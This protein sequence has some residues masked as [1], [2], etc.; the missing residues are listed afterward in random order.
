[1]PGAGFIG[2]GVFALAGE[3]TSPLLGV[4][5]IGIG[6]LLVFFGGVI[7]LIEYSDRRHALALAKKSKKSE[8]K[9]VLILCLCNRTIYI[10]DGKNTHCSWCGR[11][12]NFKDGKQRFEDK[13]AKDR[14]WTEKRIKRSSPPIPIPKPAQPV[15]S[16]YSSYSLLPFL[17]KPKEE[18]LVIEIKDEDEE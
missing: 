3:D 4:F 17:R 18:M 5:F 10:Y 1:M 8:L 12:V 7:E 14:E 15:A 2:L 6:F 9:P 16:S 11:H 13:L